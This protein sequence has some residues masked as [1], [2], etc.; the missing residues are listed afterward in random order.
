MKKKG[1]IIAVCAVAVVAGIGI[2]ARL[3]RGEGAIT[4]GA[5]TDQI[6]VNTIRVTPQEI[7]N[8]V[9]FVGQ[10][11]PSQSV[12][13]FPKTIATVQKVHVQVGDT[14]KKGDLL[15][16]LDGS[17]LESQLKAAQAGYNLALASYEQ[18]VGYGMNNTET[19]INSSY[20]S[21]KI[22]YQEASSSYDKA[23][24]AFKAAQAALDQFNAGSSISADQLVSTYEAKKAQLDKMLPDDPAY[25]GLLAELNAMK[26]SYS[27]AKSLTTAYQQAKSARDS[28]DKMLEAADLQYEAAKEAY[29]NYQD[30]GQDATLTI[31]EAQLASAKASY[32][33]A[34][35]QAEH[36]NIYAPIDGIVTACSA[37]ELEPISTS[38][39]AFIISNDNMMTV[40][41]A[42]SD[43][44]ASAIQ[45]GDL[46]T[47]YVS[48]KELPAT[49]TEV[50]QT[51]DPKTAL[52]VM[53]ASVDNS[54][55]SLKTGTAVTIRVD[56]QK[57][58]DT[59]CVPVKC[60]RYENQQ[61]YVYTVKDGIVSKVFVTTGITDDVN[62]QILTGLEDGQQ[63]ITTWHPNLKDGAQV[64]VV[65]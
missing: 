29:H 65:E 48:G 30:E 28:A 57:A 40:E 10:I 16:T 25:A 34:M 24:S 14:V 13:V 20:K 5:E 44:F 2:G 15:L 38:S 23:K 47:L 8:S 9:E 59:L 51:I 21:A 41:F 56:T 46:A 27:A 36:L 37:N 33:A 31:A 19:Q 64:N 22:S 6:P 50:S 61:S 58:F 63:V 35:K 1:I 11:Q 26:D 39:P 54:D 60:I 43:R 17:D 45:E 49:I 55:S 53:K 62:T 32:D 4:A 7:K 52:F 3:L 12:M 42:V 18:T